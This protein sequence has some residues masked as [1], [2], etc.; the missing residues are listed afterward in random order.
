MKAEVKVIF[1]SPS[2]NYSTFRDLVDEFLN[3]LKKIRLSYKDVTIKIYSDKEKTL[4]ME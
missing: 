3:E 1:D 4:L 2:N